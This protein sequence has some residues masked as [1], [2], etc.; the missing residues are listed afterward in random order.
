MSDKV[1]PCFKARLGQISGAVFEGQYGHSVT[2]QKRVYNKQTQETRYEKM[3]V[4]END[5]LNLAYVATKV[6]DW[7]LA[8]PIEKP[9]QAEAPQQPQQE[10]NDSEIPF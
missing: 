6:L 5:L 9:K 3:Y 2:I 8:N 7:L 10:Q 1:Y 4:A